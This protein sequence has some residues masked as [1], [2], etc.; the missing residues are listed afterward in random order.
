M[1]QNLICWAGHINAD[2][3]VDQFKLVRAVSFIHRLHV[4]TVKRLKYVYNYCAF[5]SK[6][7]IWMVT[8]KLFVYNVNDI[9]RFILK[10]P[11]KLSD[12][13]ALLKKKKNN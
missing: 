11:S 1:F 13:T 8:N 4:Q 3:T 7:N 2:K 6:T 12:I 9:F 10:Y 5:S